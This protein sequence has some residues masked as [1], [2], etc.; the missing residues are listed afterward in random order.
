MFSGDPYIQWFGALAP[1][2]NAHREGPF[3]DRNVIAVDGAF[4]ETFFYYTARDPATGR[5]QRKV[6][7][8]KRVVVYGLSVLLGSGYYLD[9]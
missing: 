6:T 5:L 8:V 9:Q 7:F 4:G 2:L 3:G 1:E